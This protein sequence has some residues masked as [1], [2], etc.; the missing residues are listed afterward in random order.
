MFGRI[1][2]PIWRANKTGG[3]LYR[4]VAVDCVWVYIAILV[5]VDSLDQRFSPLDLTHVVCGDRIRFGL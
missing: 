5:V 1:S 4:R 2:S 3:T